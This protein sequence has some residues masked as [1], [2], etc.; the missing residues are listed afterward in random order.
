MN[1][2]TMTQDEKSKLVTIILESSEYPIDFD[3]FSEL[4]AV[5]SED[6]PGLEFLS[7]DELSCLISDCWEMYQ[8]NQLSSPGN[9]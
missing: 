1:D 9:P 8:Q 7:E 5:L 4:I 6:I 3:L 2:H